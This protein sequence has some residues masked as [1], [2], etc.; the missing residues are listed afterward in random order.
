MQV[1]DLEEGCKNAEDCNDLNDFRSIDEAVEYG[2][3]S[4]NGMRVST[5]FCIG[6]KY[7]GD[8][9]RTY[10]TLL[11]EDLSA[12]GKYSF[13]RTEGGNIGIIEGTK[14]LVV[15]DLGEYEGVPLRNPMQLFKLRYFHPHNVIDLTKKPSTD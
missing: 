7:H 15:F 12:G 8:D 6:V 5:S 14:I 13:D 4:G 9:C 10:Y 1:T 11:V 2:R 3:Q